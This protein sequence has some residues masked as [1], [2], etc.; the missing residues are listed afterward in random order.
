MLHSVMGLEGEIGGFSK[1]GRFLLVNRR[2]QN[3]GDGDLL[4][5]GARML[6]LVTTGG[7][8]FLHS[9]GL[10]TVVGSTN[11]IR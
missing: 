1:R 10:T 6:F 5:E 9:I 8:I 2:V 7:C 4:S 11:L 3:A